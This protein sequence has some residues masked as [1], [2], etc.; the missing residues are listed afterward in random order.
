MAK[1][2]V[3]N[4]VRNTESKRYGYADGIIAEIMSNG[5]I[6]VLWYKWGKASPDTVRDYIYVSQQ[7]DLVIVGEG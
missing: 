5:T 6:V 1:Y 7:T 4:I 3:G 2:K